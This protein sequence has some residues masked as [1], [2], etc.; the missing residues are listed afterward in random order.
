MRVEGAAA[1][2]P[3]SAQLVIV[4]GTEVALVRDDFGDFHAIG[5]SCTHGA[6]SLSDGE[7][8]GRTIECWLH[9]STFDLVTGRPTCLPATKPTPV[10]TAAVDGSDVL[11]ELN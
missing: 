3:G 7:V 1:M 6:V 5:D 8:E 2:S 4:E 9:G 10:Y 11:V